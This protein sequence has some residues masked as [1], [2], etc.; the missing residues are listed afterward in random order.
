MSARL[1]DDFRWSYSK[2]SAY[3][4]CP[5]CFL[6]QY[7]RQRPR[8]NNAYAEFGTL[9]H[10]LLE[11]WATGEIASFDLSAQYAAEYDRAVE[12]PFPPFPKGQGAKYYQSGLAYF[13]RFA[14]FGTEHEVLGAEERFEISI[15]GHPFVGVVDLLL[16]HKETGALV[17][18]DHKTSAYRGMLKRLP[19]LIRQLYLYSLYVHHRHGR[20]PDILRFNVLRDGRF[21]DEPFD[22]ATYNQT[23]LWIDDTIRAAE[24]EQRWDTRPSEY[25][26]RFICGVVDDCPAMSETT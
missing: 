10:N 15:R 16:R 14:G 7:M 11:R 23:I 13:D 4:R 12:H 1:P 25:F 19:Q 3:E 22:T 26:C 8:R 17:L 24:T 9:C 6:L 5:Q 18:M 2:L 21:I 20:F